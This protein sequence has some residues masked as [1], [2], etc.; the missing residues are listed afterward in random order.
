MSYKVIYLLIAD[1]LPG[2][3]LRSKF[4]LLMICDEDLGNMAKVR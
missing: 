3:L 2:A 4:P 1:D